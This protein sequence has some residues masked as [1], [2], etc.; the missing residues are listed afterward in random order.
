MQMEDCHLA[1]IIV[2]VYLDRS[3]QCLLKLVEWRFYEEQNIDIALEYIPIKYIWVTKGKWWLC[4]GK[5]QCAPIQGVKVNITLGRW[6]NIMQRPLVI[7]GWD[8]S[9]RWMHCKEHIIS[10]I[11]PTRMHDL[12]QRWRNIRW[13]YEI[14]RMKCIWFL[15]LSG[16]ERWKDYRTVA[17][18]RRI[19]RDKLNIMCDPGLVPGPKIKEK[20]LGESWWNFSLLESLNSFP[21]IEKTYLVLLCLCLG[22]L[23]TDQIY[24]WD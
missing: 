12:H 14:Y 2:I 1:G 5:F 21:T 24:I 8:G 13:N 22:C 7:P 17:D 10:L 15:K 11:F 4:N 18:K 20:Y 23:S 6:F 9:T 16:H 3:H 19:K